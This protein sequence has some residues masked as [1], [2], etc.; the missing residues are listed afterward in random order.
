VRCASTED[1]VRAV[2]EVVGTYTP[3]AYFAQRETL[4]DLRARFS[5]TALA[6]S[7]PATLG[8]EG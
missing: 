5:P 8:W 1:I 6:R 7:L 4:A 3:V 2:L